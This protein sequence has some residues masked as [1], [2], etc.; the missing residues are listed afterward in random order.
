LEL[1]EEFGKTVQNVVLGV[2]ATTFLLSLCLSFSLQ[3]LLCVVKQLQLS[4]HMM[5]IK[6]ETPANVTTFF[7][8]IF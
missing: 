2:S 7:G 5:L 3:Q 6:M 8:Y 1:A 4:C